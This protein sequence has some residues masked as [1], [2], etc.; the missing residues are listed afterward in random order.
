MVRM[1]VGDVDVPS[2]RSWDRTHVARAAA[3]VVVMRQ[4]TSNAAAVITP[5]QG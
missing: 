2:S 1:R 5:D 3:S 4:S